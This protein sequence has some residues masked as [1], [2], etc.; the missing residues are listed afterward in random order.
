MRL[1]KPRSN[2]AISHRSKPYLQ[3]RFQNP[4]H[5]R[6][7]F[8]SQTCPWQS[9][10]GVR[11]RGR[12]LMC[13]DPP[14]RDRFSGPKTHYVRTS[15]AK[16]SAYRQAGGRQASGRLTRKIFPRPWRGRSFALVEKKAPPRSLDNTRFYAILYSAVRIVPSWKR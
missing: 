1:T 6:P 15:L 11:F 2:R 3:G 16:E 14:D 5:T 8:S 4:S 12:I 10:L 13:K 9:P 7:Y